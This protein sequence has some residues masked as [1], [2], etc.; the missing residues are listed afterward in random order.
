MT[1]QVALLN[2]HGVALASD[3]AVSLGSKTFNTVNKIFPL[4]EGE[5]PHKVAFM[6]SNAGIY[7][8]GG[9]QWE[10]VFD[11]FASSL[12]RTPRSVKEYV[13]RFRRYLKSGS[14]F[15]EKQNNIAVQRLLVDWF[16]G[17]PTL[18]GLDSLERN[19]RYNTGA[20][21]VDDMSH[22][23]RDAI[24]KGLTSVIDQMWNESVNTDETSMM[25]N[26]GYADHRNR[27]KGHNNTNSQIAAKHIVMEHHLDPEYHEKITD[28]LNIQ[29]TQNPAPPEK[30][31]STIVA[32]GFG[33]EDETPVLCEMT[34]GALIDRDA[35]VVTV[36][37]WFNIRQSDSLQD[38]GELVDKEKHGVVHN[39][40]CAIIRGYAYH[41]EMDNVLNGIHFQDMKHLMDGLPRYMYNIIMSEIESVLKGMYASGSSK[42]AELMDAIRNHRWEIP[43]TRSNH[44]SYFIDSDGDGNLDVDILAYMR[45]EAFEAV[46]EHGAVRRRQRFRAAIENFPMPNLANFA[47]SL[48]RMEAEICHWMRPVRAVGGPIDVLVITK[49]DGCQ[50]ESRS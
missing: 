43:S 45:N 31:T 47:H 41:H 2:P 4:K 26:P 30:D 16:L 13:K 32:V 14:H 12:T 38:G 24:S 39:D 6:I 10:R 19:L 28:I 7:I 11:G 15:D 9:V 46:M 20:D 50:L 37:E 35:E 48:V 40:A 21:E 34:C 27:I 42:S 22:A 5:E 25:K 3:S 36:K 33:H 18:K 29:L 17:H 44:P 23:M 1:S 8:P 49:E